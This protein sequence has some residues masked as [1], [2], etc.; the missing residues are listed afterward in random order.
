MIDSSR[1]VSP[2]PSAG[3]GPAGVD[4]G[5]YFR[6]LS[7]SAHARATAL[8][9]L[10][11]PGSVAQPPFSMKSACWYELT[12]L[13]SV[14]FVAASALCWNLSTQIGDSADMTAAVELFRVISFAVPPVTQPPQ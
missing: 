10:S 12:F 4:R 2:R 6:L 8:S 9:A 1:H 3:F 11:L 7:R 14:M 5:G 13:S